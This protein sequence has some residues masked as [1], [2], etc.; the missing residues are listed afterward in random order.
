MR[1]RVGQAFPQVT[2]NTSVNHFAFHLGEAMA[3]G[4]VIILNS[5]SFKRNNTCFW[6][7]G[8]VN[9]NSSIEL[10][11]FTPHWLNIICI[12]KF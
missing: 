6:G 11:I 4:F 12:E 3:L 7:E 9:T 10:F 5:L 1:A 2:V 8:N